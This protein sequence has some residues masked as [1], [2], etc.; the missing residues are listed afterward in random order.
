M[1]V[2]FSWQTRAQNIDLDS[3]PDCIVWKV[4]G[5]AY[6]AE[7]VNS[8]LTPL[9]VGMSLSE[10]TKLRIN[11]KSSVTIAQKNK[12]YTYDKKGEVSVSSVLKGTGVEQSES[13]GNFF[14]MASSAKG[15]LGDGQAKDTTKTRSGWGEKDKIMMI[16]PTGGK[17]PSKSLAFSWTKLEGAMKYSLV[18][19][20]DSPDQ[21]VY[22]VAATEPTTSVKLPNVKGMMIGQTY[23]AFVTAPEKQIK[24]NEVTF[25]VTAAADEDAALTSTR[26][27][28]EYKKA[29]PVQQ[30]LMEAV[31][32]ESANM[33][34]SANER[35]QKALTRDAKNRLAK[36]MYAA[37]L[38]RRNLSFAAWKYVD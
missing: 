34:A 35:Y 10:N 16:F 4:T 27:D 23:R 13:A 17:A 29:N 19:Y 2:L 24:S 36:D 20:K 6:L 18:I 15:Y 1:L 7:K 8:K 32:L 21:P 28:S 22:T 30:F 12:L 38:M 5:K 25:T 33:H 37:F 26:Q 11:K 3:S 14:K 31:A 9:T